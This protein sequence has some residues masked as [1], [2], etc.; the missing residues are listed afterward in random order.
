MG[1]RDRPDGAPERGRAERGGQALPGERGVE[2]LRRG[3]HPGRCAGPRNCTS[4]PGSIGSTRRRTTE[5]STATATSSRRSTAPRR[6]G[7]RAA[8]TRRRR[9]APAPPAPRRRRARRPRA[10]DGSRFRSRSQAGGSASAGTASARRLPAAVDRRRDDRPPSP[11]LRSSRSSAGRRPSAPARELARRDQRALELEDAGSGSPNGCV[12]TRSGRRPTSARPAA[13]SAGARASR[14]R[15]PRRSRTPSGSRRAAARP[16]SPVPRRRE[17]VLVGRGD[18]VAEPGLAPR[19][20]RRHDAGE[21]ARLRLEP[22]RAD[23]PREVAVG[24]RGEELLDRLGG[25]QLDDLRVRPRPRLGEV[26]QLGRRARRA[27]A[28]AA[29]GSSAATTSSLGRTTTSTSHG[30]SRPFVPAAAGVKSHGKSG[31]VELDAGEVVRLEVGRACERVGAEDGAR[32]DPDDVAGAVD[33]QRHVD[34]RVSLTSRP[35]GN[36]DSGFAVGCASTGASV[37]GVREGVRRA[38]AHPRQVVV[39]RAQRRSGRKAATTWSSPRSCG[40]SAG[41]A[42][43]PA[44]RRRARARP[45][46]RCPSHGRGRRRPRPRSAPARPGSPGSAPRNAPSRP[47]AAATARPGRSATDVSTSAGSAASA[48]RCGRRC[49]PRR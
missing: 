26:G 36:S 10:T 2:R 17:L 47:R 6:S 39:P 22:P 28:A 35:T 27:A 5:P 7:R 14:S 18:L 33:A 38:L 8:P 12:P 46:P 29:R 45:A 21:V 3:A 1:R 30:R 49:R 11:R 32:V 42:R 16:A 4:R 19:L 41:G 23:E 44:R 34:A 20:E 13:A 25:V 37:S 31:D 9:A 24:L 43:A 48:S 40:F 15:R